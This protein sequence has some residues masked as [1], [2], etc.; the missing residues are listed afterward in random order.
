MGAQNET[1]RR[2]AGDLIPPGMRTLSD[3]A[4]DAILFMFAGRR[5][6]A[7]VIPE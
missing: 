5:A 4:T 2:Q 6:L 3:G 7:G 1:I